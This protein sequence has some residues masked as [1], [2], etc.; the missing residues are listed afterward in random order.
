MVDVM[1]SILLRYLLS[2]EMCTYTNYKYFHEYCVT[3][4][5][6]SLNLFEIIH[7]NLG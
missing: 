5:V 7:K 1:Y 6:R 4:V 2:S 3:R